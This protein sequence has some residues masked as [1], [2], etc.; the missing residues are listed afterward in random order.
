MLSGELRSSLGSANYKFTA[1]GKISAVARGRS[2]RHRMLAQ[3]SAADNG[4]L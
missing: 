4:A 2:G 1:R 3:D